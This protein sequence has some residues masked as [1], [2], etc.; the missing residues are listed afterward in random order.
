MS[1]PASHAERLSRLRCPGVVR[2]SPT[3]TA[4]VKREFTLTK[5]SKAVTWTLVVE[6]EEEEDTL[7]VIPSF[8]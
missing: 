5:P 2:E 6:E 4:M 7:L 3:N 1:V 8:G